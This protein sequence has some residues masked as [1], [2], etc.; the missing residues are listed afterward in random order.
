[1][2]IYLERN[3]HSAPCLFMQ[4]WFRCKSVLY[5]NILNHSLVE[6][7]GPRPRNYEKTEGRTRLFIKGPDSALYQRAEKGRGGAEGRGPGGR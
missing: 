6:F 7:H 5:Q 1:M 2:N 3:T 4:P